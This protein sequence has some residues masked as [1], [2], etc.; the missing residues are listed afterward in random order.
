MKKVR[1]FII[2]VIFVL[3]GI[4]INNNILKRDVYDY[5]NA[6]II[7]NTCKEMLFVYHYT[8]NAFLD[9][10]EF[11]NITF[12]INKELNEDIIKYYEFEDYSIYFMGIK[13]I[14]VNELNNTV[15]LKEKLFKD[16]LFIDKM[17]NNMNIYLSAYDGGS[18]E[19]R[20]SRNIFNEKIKIYKCNNITSGSKNVFIS[21][22]N[23]SFPDN[24]C[25][26]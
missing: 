5:S 9:R 12:N 24:I 18:R 15:T 8:N 25:Y 14:Y 17:L 1:L 7:D 11:K 16:N 6:V 4:V 2:I 19:Y 23:L 22:E 26:S 10:Y 20:S 3:L 13:E 21:L